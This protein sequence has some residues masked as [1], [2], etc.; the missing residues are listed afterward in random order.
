[1]NTGPSHFDSGKIVYPFSQLG[2]ENALWDLDNNCPRST[3]EEGQRRLTSTSFRLGVFPRRIHLT[4]ETSLRFFAPSRRSRAEAITLFSCSCP[5]VLFLFPLSQCPPFSREGRASH[6]ERGREK[7][8]TLIPLIVSNPPRTRA[9]IDHSNR[10]A[11]FC[12]HTAR[13]NVASRPVFVR[14]RLF[15]PCNR[16]SYTRAF[17]HTQSSAHAPR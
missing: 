1:M 17:A 14:A 10:I 6:R 4:L 5:I 13:N 2:R 16:P 12:S 7:K 8:K 11:S 9:M 3:R 15:Y